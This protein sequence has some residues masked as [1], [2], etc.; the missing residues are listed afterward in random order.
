MEFSE[1]TAVDFYKNGPSFLNRYLPFWMVSHV[2][3]LLAVLLAAGVIVYP[4]LNFAPKL[5]RW[6]LQDRMR[7]LYRR[8]GIVEKAMKENMTASQLAALQSDLENIDRVSA[9]LPMRHSETYFGFKRDIDATRTHLAS[10]LVE[11]RGQTAN[12]A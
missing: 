6:F 7:K 4:L 11:A 5:Y 3:R 1:P 9:V 2:Q 10:R 12:T 8:L